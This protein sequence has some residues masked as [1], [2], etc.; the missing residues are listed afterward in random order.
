MD[1]RYAHITTGK[2]HKDHQFYMIVDLTN[3]S[4]PTEVGRW[5]MPG[6][7]KGD[8]AELPPRHP[9]PF[10]FAYRPH[11]T[12]C[13]PERPDRAYVGYP[14]NYQLLGKASPLLADVTSHPKRN[15]VR[16]K[17]GTEELSFGTTIQYAGLYL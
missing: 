3:P 13:Y 14:G 9:E 16:G 10:D 1:G 15:A 8:D 4:K 7:R 2:H 6:Q 17:L 11:H 12:L 5:W